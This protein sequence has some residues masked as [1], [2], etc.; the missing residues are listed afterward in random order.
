MEPALGRDLLDGPPDRLDVAGVKRPG[1]LL[2]GGVQPEPRAQRVERVGGLDGRNAAASGKVGDAVAPRAGRRRAGEVALDR[3][4]DGRV[5]AVAGAATV[6]LPAAH[7][8][9]ARE[10]IG[11]DPRCELVVRRRARRGGALP[12]DA[13]RRT[14]TAPPRLAREI[15][16]APAREHALLEVGWRI[17]GAGHVAGQC[18]KRPGTPD[19]DGP[20]RRRACGRS[21]QASASRP[22][23]APRTPARRARSARGRAD[24]RSRC[25]GA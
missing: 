8:R 10:D 9:V 14:L 7:R 24:R 22:R 16:L 17:F 15:A 4:L 12:D 5:V 21:G 13:H 3:D 25:L 19:G 11:E 2:A 6:D 18:R 20:V 23:R 1:H